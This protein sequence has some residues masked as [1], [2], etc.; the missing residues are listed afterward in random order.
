MGRRGSIRL[1]SHPTMRSVRASLVF[2]FS[3]LP[4]LPAFFFPRLALSSRS[5]GQICGPNS[6]L[7]EGQLPPF[8]RSPTNQTMGPW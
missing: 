6:A 2:F 4:S 5:P 8:T 3:P 7:G 1:A